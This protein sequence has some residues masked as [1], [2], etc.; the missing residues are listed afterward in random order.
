MIHQPPKVLRHQISLEENLFYGAGKEQEAEIIRDAKRK[1]M[2]DAKYAITEAVLES[3]DAAIT[4][5]YFWSVS[6]ERAAFKRVVTL[7]VNITP[8]SSPIT[9]QPAYVE[10]TIAML[11]QLAKD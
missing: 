10:K 5:N 2:I 11:E 3:R 1:I 8:Y 7:T 9:H 6:R 4:V